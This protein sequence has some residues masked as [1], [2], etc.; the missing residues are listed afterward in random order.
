MPK[1]LVTFCP[2]CQHKI[3]HHD[4]VGGREGGPDDGSVAVCWYCRKVAVYRVT[5]LGPV[6]KALSPAAERQMRAAPMVQRVL[7]AMAE[8]INVQS[9]IARLRRSE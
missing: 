1:T 3:E 6:L 2:Y 7:A 9:A 8:S 4:H 5:A